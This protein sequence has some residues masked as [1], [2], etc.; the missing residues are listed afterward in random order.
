[1][2][3][4]QIIEYLDDNDEFKLLP[5]YQDRFKK[6]LIDYGV[7]ENSALIDLMS[8]YSGE[9]HGKEGFIINVADDLS[10]YD[11]SVTKQLVDNEGISANYI[12]LFNFEFDDYLLYNKEDDSVVLINGGNIDKLK[13]NNFDK[14]WNSFN[15]FLLDYFGIS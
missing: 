4:K 3:D 13:A 10:E 8:T 12:S 11:N 1:M 15:E 6:I 2:I 9:F 7:N 5:E 14:K